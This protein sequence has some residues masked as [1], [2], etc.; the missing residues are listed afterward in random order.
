MEQGKCSGWPA[1]LLLIFQARGNIQKRQEEACYV[2]YAHS[3]TPA[4]NSRGNK[5]LE[6]HAEYNAWRRGHQC[7]R[8]NKF[9][10]NVRQLCA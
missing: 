3:L 4:E 8:Y 5:N 9:L 7:I 2:L 1:P 6:I 10:L